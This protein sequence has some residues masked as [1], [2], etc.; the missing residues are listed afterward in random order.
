MNPKEAAGSQAVDYVTDGMVVGLGTGSTAEYAIRTLGRRVAQGLRVQAVPTSEASARLA[1]RLNIE[2]LDLE[3]GLAVDLTIDGADEVDPGLN[4][5]KGLGGALLR[6]KI[7]ART[8][9]QLIIIVDSSKM[10]PRLGTR[11]P[12]PVEV[13]P[14][15]SSLVRHQLG[16]K[17]LRAGLRRDADTGGPYETDNGNLILDCHFPGGIHDPVHAE[18]WINALPGVVENGL[19]IDLAN[20]VIVGREDG[21]C[22]QLH[23]SNP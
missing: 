8:S 1:R 17:G 5:V 20:L 22:R 16:E 13:V 21:T 11:S 2:V 23:R 7:V 3:G 10:V 19:F 4:L 18:S 9:K 6:E 14:F 12:L 15:A